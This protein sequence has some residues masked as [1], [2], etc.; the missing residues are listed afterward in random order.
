MSR[1]S[2][3]GELGDIKMKEKQNAQEQHDACEEKRTDANKEISY[4]LV[5]TAFVIAVT[6]MAQ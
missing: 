2:E 5:N 1:Y 3:V 6:H 4:F